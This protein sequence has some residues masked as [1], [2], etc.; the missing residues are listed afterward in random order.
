[1]E[2]TDKNIILLNEALEGVPYKSIQ[3]SALGNGNIMVLV[4]LD[5]PANWAHDI[6][7]N[8]NYFRMRIDPSFSMEVFV[9]SIYK[10]NV[11]YDNRL[12]TKFRRTKGK[13]INDVITKLINFIEKIKTELA[14]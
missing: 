7:E 5:T 8:S 2:Q 6:M 4:S 14:S 12:K 1:M 11:C 13:N 10:G 9:Q 3:K